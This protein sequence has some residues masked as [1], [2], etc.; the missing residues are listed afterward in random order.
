MKCIATKPWR[1]LLLTVLMVAALSVASYSSTEKKKPKAY[2]DINAIGH[3]VIG[4]QNGYGNW[5][6]LDKEKQIG[7]QFSAEYEKSTPLIHDA[8]TQAY[9]D[10]LTRTV[11]QNS[12]TQFPINT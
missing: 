6:S 2:R 11:S 1:S 10:G 5:Y 4:Y 3:R 12:D 9:L 8:A 7:A